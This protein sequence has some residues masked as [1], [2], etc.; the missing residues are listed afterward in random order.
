MT[1]TANVWHLEAADWISAKDALSASQ[2]KRLCSGLLEDPH[3]PFKGFDPDLIKEIAKDYIQ[4]T[5]Q[6]TAPEVNTNSSDDAANLRDT[7]RIDGFLLGKS[8]WPLNHLY[9]TCPGAIFFASVLDETTKKNKKSSASKH[10]PLAVFPQKLGEPVLLATLKSFSRCNGV[11]RNF[12]FAGLMEYAHECQNILEFDEARRIQATWAADAYVATSSV[13]FRINMQ[14]FHQ[15][16]NLVLRRTSNGG[17][18]IQTRVNYPI[19][20]KYLLANLFREV[21]YRLYESHILTKLNFEKKSTYLVARFIYQ[22]YLNKRGYA[23]RSIIDDGIPL[24]GGR[25]RASYYTGISED[26]A[27]DGCIELVR[28]SCLTSKPGQGYKI[29]KANF[30]RLEKYLVECGL[31]EA[32]LPGSSQ[33]TTVID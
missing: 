14:R 30:S 20:R 3:S 23:S 28:I 5:R 32:T 12:Q 22:Y 31:A 8:G 17:T 27:S 6:V 9:F 24:K 25:V 7:E 10:E 1:S 2:M 19:H 33:G 13:L 21:S 29:T 15:F 16:L 11:L 4:C 26:D 18:Q